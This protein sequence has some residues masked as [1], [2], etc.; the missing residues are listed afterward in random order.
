MDDISLRQG[1][2]TSAEK[3]MLRNLE[4]GQLQLFPVAGGAKSQ[5]QVMNEVALV[6]SGT[7]LGENAAKLA[8]AVEAKAVSA[9]PT[10]LSLEVDALVRTMGPQAPETNIARWAL[11]QAEGKFVPPGAPITNELSKVP[12][13]R[14]VNI[15]EQG[16]SNPFIVRAETQKLL[17]T[18]RGGPRASQLKAQQIQDIMQ[19]AND[20]VRR[21]RG[22]G[23]ELE[24]G[25]IAA[26]TIKMEAALASKEVGIQTQDDAARLMGRMMSQHTTPEAVVA[27]AKDPP[28]EILKAFPAGAKR[29]QQM[30]EDRAQV[31]KYVFEETGA[32]QFK[33]ETRRVPA[34]L[35]ELR[36]K[37]SDHGLQVIPRGRFTQG[38]ARP[39]PTTA[40]REVID[41]FQMV[42]GGQNVRKFKSIKQ[43]NA[44]VTALEEGKIDP[45]DIHELRALAY[46][47]S[48]DVI[49]NGNKTVTLINTMSGEVLQ[50]RPV[51]DLKRATE[52]VRQA[53][54]IASAT[55]E[56]GP[57]VPVG[58]HPPLSGTGSIGTIAAEQP[59]PADVCGLPAL[60]RGL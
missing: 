46:P 60:L 53:P 34:G 55:R 28:P 41:S 50:G 36:R 10:Q 13:L 14:G 8:R 39:H 23:Q 33:P 12:Q 11:A 7:K 59:P 56:I 17:T 26:L 45:T 18:L 27:L 15:V 44:W 29:F 54:N 25:K 47:R 32:K 58:T 2:Q 48:I 31:L 57:P 20:S 1:S 16:P 51:I 37:A 38:A 21:A 4:K 24:P 43:A 6:N 40:G 5:A 35:D 22:R 3:T 9:S 19:E 30:A 42:L 49:Y 52:V